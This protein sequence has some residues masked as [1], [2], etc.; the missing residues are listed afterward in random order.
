[1]ELSD[2]VALEAKTTGRGARWGAIT[3]A[4][5]EMVG[6]AAS[7]EAVLPEWWSDAGLLRVSA[8]AVAQDYGAAAGANLSVWRFRACVL[9]G[10]GDEGEPSWALSAPRSDGALPPVRV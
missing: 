9:A 10:G 5:F 4:I 7:D 6:D 2:L 3:A 1:M 8:E